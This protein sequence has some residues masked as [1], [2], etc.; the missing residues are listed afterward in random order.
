MVRCSPL[1]AFALILGL[2]GVTLFPVV[3]EAAVCNLT[4]ENNP[5]L[6]A[7]CG[8]NTQVCTIPG[9]SAP[10]G[11]EL[12]FGTRKVVFTGTFDVSASNANA[13]TLIVRAGQ[14]E[15]RGA[16]KARSDD[17]KRGGT[18]RLIATDTILVSGTV[19]VSGNSGG[20]MRLQAGNSV[21]L[22]S[23]GLLRSRGIEFSSTGNSASGGAIELFAGTTVTHRGAIDLSGGVQGGG[24]S[25]TTQSGTDTLIAQSIDATGGAGDGGDVD[26]LGGDDVRIEKSIDVSS[27]NAGGSGDIR[28][29]AGVDRVGG[30]KVGGT[31][32]V[33]GDMR[34]NGS[35]DIDGG[36]DGGEINLAA[37]GP[38]NVS[39][40]L[41]A[42]GANPSG[43]GGS[44]VIDSSDNV[45]GRVTALDGDLNL[46][47]VIDVHGPQTISN[48]DSGSG[49]DV[50]IFV[51]RDGTISGSMDLSGSDGGGSLTVLI[52]RSTTFG[53]TVNARGTATFAGGG[54]VS[55]KSG[56][57]TKGALQVTRTLDVSAATSGLS[58]DVTLA[59]C[60]L[61]LA[62]G[63]TVNASAA[64]PNGNPRIDLIAPGTLAIGAGGTYRADP[65]GRI[66]L[67]HPAAIQPQIGTNVTFNP[68][69]THFDNPAV[70][71]ACAVCGDG[72][73]QPGEPCDK[74]AAADGACCND[75]C[76]AF[77][78]PTI[79]PTPTLS[80]T[81]T[82]PTKTATPTRTKTP[83]PTPTATETQ[84]ATPDPNGAT[85]TPTPPPTVDPS[86]TVVLPFTEPKPV[87]A[88]EKTL[89]KGTST[90][91][92]T[93]MKTLE[94]CS[95]DAFK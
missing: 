23:T 49:G 43:S 37:F 25:L 93:M 38:V 77:A 62:G 50:D 36:Y 44:V 46:T 54:S 53:A 9:G 84:T 42:V 64:S 95:L 59:G 41:R 24:G 14:I 26:I 48:D 88:C 73:R 21:E 68:A 75:D 70:Y 83:T 16:L 7:P 80:P 91:V 40:A 30:I 22:T 78:C 51:G 90:L 89:G 67:V 12:D 57:G 86:P 94:S 60:D 82:I 3:G 39:G 15:V 63:L 55:M 5:I 11:C 1:R 65:L 33:I 58:G 31:L 32:T 72:I 61:T 74:A 87:L 6:F 56:L 18:I 35:A 8:P 19:D 52:G 66:A 27:T 85:P 20:L 2:W 47:S 10:A 28:I 76:S 79:T 69:P 45:I 92:T 4:P 29:R 81:S 13:G 71:P 17:N 34:A